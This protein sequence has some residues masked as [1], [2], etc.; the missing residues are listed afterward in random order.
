MS[1]CCRSRG[2]RR[3][4]ADRGCRTGRPCA[5]SC[6]S[7]HT[8]TQWERLPQEIGCGSGMTCWRRLAAWNEAGVWD[9]LHVLLEKL[10]SRN[11]LDFERVVIDSS[12]VRAARRAQKRRRWCARR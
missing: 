8:G 6:S 11:Q 4:R 1:R 7:L 3:S 10:R 5:A 9:Q 12:H 2:R